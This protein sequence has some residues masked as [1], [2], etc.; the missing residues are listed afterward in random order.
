MSYKLS[1]RTVLITTKRNKTL[2]EKLSISSWIN[3]NLLRRFY[4]QQHLKH[5]LPMSNTINRRNWL[6]NAG[7]LAGG[8]S[9]MP[10]FL[11]KAAANPA[12]QQELY[13]DFSHEYQAMQAMSALPPA[14]V[15]ARLGANENPWGLSDK[16]KKAVMESLTEANRYG[17]TLSRDLTKLIATK[18]NVP[19][20][21][22]EDG[23]KGSTKSFVKLGCG[24]SELLSAAIMHFGQKGTIMVGDP[25]YISGNDEKVPMDKV[26]LTAGYQYDLDA[27]AAKAD[28]AKHSLI[29]ICNPNNPTGNILP[30]DKLRAF[31]DKVADK[32]PVLIDEAYIDYAQD[33][34][35][36][37]MVDK[38]REGKNVII[39][40]TMSKLYAFAGMR[41]GYALGKP[42]LLNPMSKYTM[43]GGGLSVPTMM[44]GIA[45]L[46]DTDYQKTILS[47]T[48]ASKAYLLDFLKTAG[49]SA[50]PSYA[51]FVL[52]PIK[53][54][55][56]DLTSKMREDGVMV[57]NWFFDA[58]HWCRVSIG[59]IDEMKAFT[60]SFTKVV[61]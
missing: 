16:A 57:R 24:S 41:L 29:Y 47:N 49:Y 10:S 45:A 33:P 9:V 26:K 39:L 43:N 58:Q 44:A 8:L 31:I 37:C 59:T 21:P 30:A 32:I 14:A 7:L 2:F 23:W 42:D 19:L 52:F 28:P 17:M 25:C 35:A 50:V 22:V 18:D 55:G 51:N 11:Q 60:E 56:T 15:K 3:T 20:P 4:L 1:F 54:K 5:E 38:I 6:K 13:L 46:Q 61:S 27:M 36:D 34:I 53:M 40:R 12:L 48:A